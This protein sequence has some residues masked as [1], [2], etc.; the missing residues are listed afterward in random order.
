MAV[1]IRWPRRHQNVKDGRWGHD[2]IKREAEKEVL[3]LMV[4]AKR[5]V[6]GRWIVRRRE[7]DC[8]EGV[9]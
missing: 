3:E 4:V 7:S 6:C 1:G 5:D 2:T 9:P 8:R